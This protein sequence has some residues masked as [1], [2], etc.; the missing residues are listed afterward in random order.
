MGLADSRLKRQRGK[1]MPVARRS[2]V[3]GAPAIDRSPPPEPNSFMQELNEYRIQQLE[4]E[5][6][7]LRSLAYVTP[8]G[9]SQLTWRERTNQLQTQ[10]AQAAPG[11]LKGLE[12]RWLTDDHDCETCGS[13][14]AE[15]AEVYF[16]G[17][18][19]LSLIPIAACYDG[20]SYS[21]DDVYR[22]IFAHLGFTFVEPS[23]V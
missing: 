6:A 8:E 5:V 12:I 3:R 11:A 21:S 15:G 4:Q 19:I 23:S 20:A 16:N 14:W 18:L 7:A 1:P 13:A 2:P 9:P 22:A 17:E 10:L